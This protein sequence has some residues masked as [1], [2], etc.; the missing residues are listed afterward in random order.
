LSVGP[1]A[2]YTFTNVTAVHTISATF[3]VDTYTITATAGANG[4]ISPS[5]AVSVNCGTNQTFTIAPD[6]CS[7]VA[8]VLVDSISVGAVSSYTF[9]NVTANHTIDASFTNST[10]TITATAGTNGTINPG[11]LVSVNCGTNQDFTITPDTGYPIVD[12]VVDSQSVGPVSSYSFTNITANHT[13]DASF[14]TELFRVL[15]ITRQGNDVQLTWPA[16]GGHN[17][18]V[19][20]TAG[21]NGSYTN[22]FTNLSSTI[23]I[24]GIGESTTNYVDVGGATNAP[25]RYYRIRLDP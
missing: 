9:T 3:A 10:Y 7:Q 13:I 14:A 2:S 19:Q 25:A 16:V 6:A 8:D 11:G 24:S 15:S 21:S 20:S 22:D 12:V 1:V 23:T 4:T 17:F 5:G 18:V